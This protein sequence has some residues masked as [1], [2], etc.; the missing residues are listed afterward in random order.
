MDGT[1][2]A[3]S[4]YQWRHEWRSTTFVVVFIPLFVALGFWQ[5]GRADEKQGIAERWD[6]QRG[7]APVPL[8][9]LSPDDPSIAYRPVQL[10][11]EFDAQRSFLLDN[12][13]RQG[14]YGVEVLA[15]LRQTATGD[16][17]LVNRGWTE[18]DSTRRVLPDVA[19]PTGEQHLTGHVHV[20]LGEAYT[21]G[22]ISSDDGWPR[23]IQAVDVTSL[24]D[25]ADLPLYPY[26]VR[27]N[28]ESPGALLADWPVINMRPEKHQAYAVQWF[29]MAAVLAVLFV[30]RSSNL[31]DLF[32]SRRGR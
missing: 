31:S 21:L 27:L 3:M 32:E 8:H 1:A 6:E 22:P 30:W 2:A 19:V 11:G 14:R 12:R 4:K 17:V 15:L 10:S 18:A 16:W 29:T 20:P 23:L 5:L 25:L 26:V 7:Q 24:A 13:L 28:G 9:A